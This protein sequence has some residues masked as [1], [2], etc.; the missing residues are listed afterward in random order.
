MFSETVPVPEDVCHLSLSGNSPAH[1]KPT[2]GPSQC[3][4][5]V[6]MNASF[7]RE[8]MDSG[9]HLTTWEGSWCS[10]R[11]GLTHSHPARVNLC[12]DSKEPGWLWRQYQHLPPPCLHS[13]TI[14]APSPDTIPFIGSHGGLGQRSPEWETQCTHSSLVQGKREGYAV[15][16]EVGGQPQASELRV[17][18]GKQLPSTPSVGPCPEP[19]GL[20]VAGQAE[21]QARSPLQ[22]L[23]HHPL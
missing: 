22:S 1:G 5:T 12:C 2:P 19:R 11:V 23:P 4:F 21:E 18:A 7:L 9:P 15:C 13:P 16:C 14:R 17:W 20:F 3:R 8:G 10:L 6:T